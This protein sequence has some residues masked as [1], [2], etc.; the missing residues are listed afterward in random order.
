MA[1]TARSQS[2]S[3]PGSQ[4]G[5][6]K[7]TAANGESAQGATPVSITDRAQR[8]GSYTDAS[9]RNKA[10]QGPGKDPLKTSPNGQQTKKQ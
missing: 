2:A 9:K 4:P 10:A 6:G 1:A 3:A 7:K 5:A 8:E